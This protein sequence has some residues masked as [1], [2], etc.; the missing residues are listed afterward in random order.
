[1]IELLGIGHGLIPGVLDPERREATLPSQDTRTAALDA[2]GLGEEPLEQGVDA[3]HLALVDAVSQDTNEAG[4]DETGTKRL[5]KASPA[6]RIIGEEVAQVDPDDCRHRA[7]V[8][9]WSSEGSGVA[10]C[11]DIID[12]VIRYGVAGVWAP[13]CSDWDVASNT[14]GPW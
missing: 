12:S 10:G 7:E 6:R 9:V 4:V 14:V 2:V 1:V 5:P 8:S 3:A 11:L 13:G